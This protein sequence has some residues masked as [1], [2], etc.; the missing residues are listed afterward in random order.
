MKARSGSSRS[1]A[2]GLAGSS[3]PPGARPDRLV[4]VFLFLS[5]SV[6]LFSSFAVDKHLS[7]DGVNYFLIGAAAKN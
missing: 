7:A 6:A 2:A 1:V 4:F 3:R 5:I